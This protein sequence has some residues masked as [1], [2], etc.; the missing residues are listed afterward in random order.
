[1]HPQAA[2]GGADVRAHVRA[3]RHRAELDLP[4]PAPGSC[5]LALH[6]R[7]R[8]WRALAP[9]VYYLYTIA[10]VSSACFFMFARSKR[11]RRL[12]QE[13]FVP[14]VRVQMAPPQS[15]FCIQFWANSRLCFDRL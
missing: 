12:V 13:N 10:A 3:G 9:K 1:M 4:A 6:D 5:R 7:T 14:I 8:D 15:P 2:V 11:K